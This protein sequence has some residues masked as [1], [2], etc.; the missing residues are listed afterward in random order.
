MPCIKCNGYWQ[1]SE[2]DLQCGGMGAAPIDTQVHCFVVQTKKTGSGCKM[3]VKYREAK[4]AA[5]GA[6]GDDW[7]DAG[8]ICFRFQL[9]VTD[10]G[11]CFVN[12]EPV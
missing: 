5:E 4:A 3:Q 12:A 6:A 1:C 11:V 8:E 7:V 10:D 2:E 9:Y